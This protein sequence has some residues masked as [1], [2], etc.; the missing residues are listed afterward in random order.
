MDTYTQTIPGAS[1]PSSKSELKRQRRTIV[2]KRRILEETLVEGASVARIARAHGVNQ[3]RSSTGASCMKKGGSG[4][5][6]Q[7]LCS[8]SVTHQHPVSLSTL[9]ASERSYTKVSS[10]SSIQIEL[11]HA[12]VRIQGNPDPVVVRVL[13]ECLQ[14]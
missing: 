10:E 11:R 5:P 8:V 3:T 1:G 6:A 12:H 2:E 4:Q 14:R 13:L 9:P 7:P